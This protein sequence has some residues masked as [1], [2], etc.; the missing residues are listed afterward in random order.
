M[1]GFLVEFESHCIESERE[2]DENGDY[3]QYGSWSESYSNSIKS[4]IIKDPKFPDVTST[5]DIERGERV[6]VVWVEYSNGDSF[7]H[8]HRGGTEAVAVFKDYRTAE[9]LK[10]A[11]EGHSPDRNTS[12]W[13]NKYKLKLKTSDGQELDI[14]TGSWHDYFGGLDEVHIDDVLVV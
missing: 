12:D 8:S 5:L 3:V 13:E 1:A 7:G 4:R 14:Y 10:N 2:T 6:F 11:I 9:E